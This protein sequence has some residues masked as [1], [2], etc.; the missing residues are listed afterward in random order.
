MPS[1]EEKH[2]QYAGKCP[3]CHQKL[4]KILDMPFVF[5]ENV[6]VDEMHVHHPDGRVD[7]FKLTSD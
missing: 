1:C 5:D 4:P 7:K 6:P 3:Y 2:H